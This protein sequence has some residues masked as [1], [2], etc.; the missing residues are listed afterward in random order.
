[1]DQYWRLTGGFDNGDI[2]SVVDRVAGEVLNELDYRKE[3]K[4]AEAFEAS[5]DFLGFVGEI[6]RATLDAQHTH[7][8]A[9]RALTTGRA[10]LVATPSP[11]DGASV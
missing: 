3:A 2:R 10:H 1:M 6:E 5:L 7:A 9:T 4:N 11:H 8:H